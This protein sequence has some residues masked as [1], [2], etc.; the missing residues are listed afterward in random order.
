M[1][2]KEDRKER[3]QGQD[4]CHRQTSTT[5]DNTKIS[6]REDGRGT[7]Q[8]RVSHRPG[9]TAEDNRKISHK[10]DRKERIQGQDQFCNDCGKGF[11]VELK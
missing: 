7:A 6:H 1:L 8:G 3:I 4:L 2:H 10:E 9:S 11:T 5:Q